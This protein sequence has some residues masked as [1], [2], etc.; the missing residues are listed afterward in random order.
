MIK[1]ITFIKNLGVFKN[2]RKTEDTRD[3]SELNIL[4]GWNYSGK[5]TISRLLQCFEKGYLHK[6]Y[7]GSEFKIKDEN[8]REYSEKD[9][10]DL[11][12]HVRVFNTD[13]IH[14]N[15]NWDGDAFS[16]ILLL[17][18]ESIKAQEEIE[19]RRDKIRK[20]TKII[21]ELK[22]TT[23]DTEK[24]MEIEMT[25]TALDIRTKLSIVET[26]TKTHLKSIIYDIKDKYNLFF[27][28]SDKESKLTQDA[29]ISEGNKLSELPLYKPNLSLIDLKLETEVL[30]KEIPTFSN[31]I[32]YFKQNPKVA[33]WVEEGISL[34][35][36]N[37]ECAF[38]GNII[39]KERKDKLFAHFS[40]DL[41]NHK[42]KIENLI[43]RIT[44]SKISLPII[45]EKE[46]YSI[47]RD[48]F[49]TT[50]DGLNNAIDDY[51]NSLDMLSSNLKE[52]IDNPFKPIEL[53][54][55]S[56]DISGEIEA[57][58][59]VIRTINDH[60][61]QFETKKAEA[62]ELLKK[63]FV[64]KFL[65]NNKIVEREQKIALYK[66]REG[67][68]NKCRE[69]LKREMSSIEA[70]INK[71]QKGMEVLN[72]YIFSFLGGDEIKIELVQIDNNER[73]T[74]KRNTK[75]AVNLSEGE[76]TAI[77]FSFFLT[78]LEEISDF[79]KTIVYID[80]PISSLDSN[81]IFQVN[82][83]INGFFFKKVE[84]E[85][86]HH[87]EL[88]CHQLFLSTH[89]YDF[90]SLMSELPN[91]KK[92]NKSS[93]YQVRR[94]NSTESTL[95]N[96]PRAI[97]KYKSEYHFL[98]SEIHRFYTSESKDDYEM[99]MSL[100][101]IMRRFVE[102]YTYSKIPSDKDTTVDHRAT[103]LWGLEKSKNIMKVLHHFSHSGNIERIVR[104]SDLICNIEP[105]INDLMEELQKDKE[106]YKALMKSLQ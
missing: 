36:G 18:E 62:I 30:L 14:D 38:C 96:L 35:E 87:W 91:A 79:N 44:E 85:K 5:T 77:A 105:A 15:I 84:D 63:H 65:E 52:K 7:S 55:T 78:K 6:D 76:K 75:K 32:E 42:S 19:K 97:R 98:F 88:R 99:L 48:Y 100:P 10:N 101:N 25:N 39:T 93:Y 11:S 21:E 106:H 47:T 8:E 12:N 81:H 3:F 29:K 59:T 92:E 1:S 69:L 94:I 80:D 95:I 53:N 72:N 71:A 57:Y 61:A 74:L 70:K 20:I 49:I 83:L 17:G 54:Y 45:G 23:F 9:L 28:D 2:Y 31:T 73:F 16:P 27:L 90:F 46:I 67:K 56:V 24:M 58:N 86:N 102:L 60:T 64:A 104:N 37:N 50:R 34:H 41:R 43:S 51:N 4:Y 89:N 68:L 40:K 103:E 33:R 66:G 82:A 22:K 26:F 13:F